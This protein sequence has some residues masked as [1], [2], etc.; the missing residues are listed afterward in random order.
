MKTYVIM[1]TSIDKLSQVEVIPHLVTF[2][3]KFAH[4]E[5]D[6][7]SKINHKRMYWVQYVKNTSQKEDEE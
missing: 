1:R 3:K 6:R 5:A 4:I 2:N 7:L